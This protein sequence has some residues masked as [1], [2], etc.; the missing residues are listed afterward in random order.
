MTKRL[1]FF[2][3]RNV[4]KPDSMH[5]A[6]YLFIFTVI[7]SSLIGSKA[8]GK[9]IYRHTIK[10]K[11]SDP[12]RSEWERILDLIL[13]DDVLIKYLFPYCWRYVEEKIITG[14][15]K[16]NEEIVLS[17]KTP[18]FDPLDPSG[19]EIFVEE[20]KPKIGFH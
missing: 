8:E 2:E 11:I 19:F 7:D 18:Q 4:T 14:S 15:L 20:E 9:E 3:T 1:K 16:K 6:E 17:Q 10:A 13:E 5:I 12:Q